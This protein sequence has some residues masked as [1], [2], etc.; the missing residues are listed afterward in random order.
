MKVRFREASRADVDRLCEVHRAAIETL[1]SEAYDDRQLAAWK[2]GVTP[3]LYPV[4]DSNTHFLV[5][6]TDGQVIGFGWMKPRAD[7]YFTIDVGGEITGVYVHPTAAGRGVGTRLLDRLERF[8]RR[9]SVR[10]LGLWASLN[11]VPFY[12]EH[13]YETVTNQA[14]EYDDGT[15]IPVR[16]MKKELQ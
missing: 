2:R 16:E 9:A 3:S 6:E 15:E 7:D 11:A 14:L 10:S 8:G 5:A 12:S 1:G 13:G 4:E